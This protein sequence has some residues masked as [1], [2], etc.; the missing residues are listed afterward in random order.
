MS[1]TEANM[2][3]FEKTSKQDFIALQCNCLDY[4]AHSLKHLMDLWNEWTLL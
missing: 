2:E 1:T 3:W 4:S